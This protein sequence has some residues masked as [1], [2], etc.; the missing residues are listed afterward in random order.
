MDNQITERKVYT[1]DDIDYETRSDAETAAKRCG[2]RD[3]FLNVFKGELSSGSF[4][5]KFTDFAL[6][7]FD[8]LREVFTGGE[9][10]PTIE[11]AFDYFA[12][13]IEASGTTQ[14]TG[15]ITHTRN[16][17]LHYIKQTLEVYNHG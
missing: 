2:R 3:A 11:D 10:Q 12:G 9:V 8:E 15:T 16:E 6:E 14:Q 5:D 7:H 4:I 1:V 13:A 17:I